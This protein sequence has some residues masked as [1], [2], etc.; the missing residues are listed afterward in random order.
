MVESLLAG[1]HLKSN[2]T[3]FVNDPISVGMVPHTSL[4]SKDK[5]VR[6]VNNPISD[7]IDPVN[8]VETR[9]MD[10]S[11]LVKLWIPKT[12][13]AVVLVGVGVNVA[14]TVGAK[15]GILEGSMLGYAGLICRAKYRPMPTMTTAPRT[16]RNMIPKHKRLP[17]G[18]LVS[19]KHW[20][21][22]WIG[23]AS[24]TLDGGSSTR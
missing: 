10:V 2:S 9:D 8:C 12:T 24:Y 23:C 4:F 16:S 22:I 21:S 6:A 1:Y 5:E 19:G 13:V 18:V 3:N 11:L 15:L 17:P 7:G 20:C 14:M